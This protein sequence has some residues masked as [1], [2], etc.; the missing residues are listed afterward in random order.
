LSAISV[1][2]LGVLLIALGIVFFALEMITPTF[3][4]LAISGVIALLIGSITLIEPESPYGDIP[5]QVIVPVVIFSAAFFLGVAYLGLKAQRKKKLSGTE[6]MIGQIGIAKTDINEKGGKVFV[7][8]EIWDAYSETPIKEGEEVKI[9]KVE[10][11][12]LKVSRY[13]KHKGDSD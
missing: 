9:L 10:G 1:N 6:G 8:G 11:L 3:G 5:L 7:L 13:H 12:K 4:A 2:W